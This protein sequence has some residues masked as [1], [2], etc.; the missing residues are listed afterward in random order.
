MSICGA[1]MGNA[2]LL[3]AEA[4][5]EVLGCDQHAY[6]PMSDVLRAAGIEVLPGFDEARLAAL[7][8]DLVVIGNVN[9]RGNPEVEWLLESRAIPYLSLPEALRRFVLGARRN[10]VVAGTLGMNPGW[11]L[12]GAPRDLPQGAALGDP[13]A[14]FVIEGDEYDSAFFDKRSKFIHYA[15][16]ILAL[17]N[18]EFDHADIFRDLEDIE[19]TFNHLLRIVPRDGWIVYNGDDPNLARLLPVPWAR[20]VKVGT[21]P[22][23]D[24][25]IRAFKEDARGAS[26]QLAWR[27]TLWGRVQWNQSG[28]YN[29]RNAALALMSAGLAINPDDPFCKL[30]PGVLKG[31]RGVRRR[32]EVLYDKNGTVVLSDFGHHPTAIAA[33]LESLRARYPRH[34]LTLAW[35]ARSNTACR[36]LLQAAFARAFDLA[37]RVHLGAVFRAER[38]SDAERI[39]LAAIAA[40][41]GSKATA[42]GDNARLRDA[43][44]AELRDDPAQCVV[45]F[46]NGSFDGVMPEVVAAREIESLGREV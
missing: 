42:H 36:N 6:P 40:E 33:T 44:L 23:N 20:S 46:S 37:D 32:Q 1:G 16:H 38:Y 3:L 21:G 28:L 12:G 11:M 22:E 14:P 7:A 30:D 10:L 24:L 26:F 18:L 41:L 9:T 5:H 8:P 35:E 17:N 13:A 45:F 34:R 2:A 39:D 4:G 19:R 29:A 31:F 27:G 25:R 43:L 15:P